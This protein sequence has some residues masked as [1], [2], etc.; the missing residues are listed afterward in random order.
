MSRLWLPTDPPGLGRVPARPAMFDSRRQRNRGMPGI[1]QSTPEWDNRLIATAVS[2]GMP[3][4]DAEQARSHPP[5]RLALLM[6]WC[7][8]KDAAEGDPAA[9]RL[10]DRYREIFRRRQTGAVAEMLDAHEQPANPV[11]LT[12][13]LGL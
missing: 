7:A 8:V 4:E 11:E 3:R 9:R 2:L 13:E 12:S 10:I 6:V 5:A 1:S